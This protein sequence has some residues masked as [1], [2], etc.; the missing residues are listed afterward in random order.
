MVD[1]QIFK[2][3]ELKYGR[4]ANIFKYGRFANIL[5]YGRFANRYFQ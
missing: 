5:K 3:K 4:F 2:D 1:L